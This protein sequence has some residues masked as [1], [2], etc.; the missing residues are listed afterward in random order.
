MVFVVMPTLPLT[1]GDT[2]LT[3]G[4]ALTVCEVDFGTNVANKRF[5]Q[6]RYRISK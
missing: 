3:I 6:E 4:I 2:I 5:N 1:R